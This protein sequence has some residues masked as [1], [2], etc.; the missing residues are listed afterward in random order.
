MSS[1][2]LGAGGGQSANIESRDT[3]KRCR[4]G[5]NDT[6]T[7][8]DSRDNESQATRSTGA[9]VGKQ[10]I[11]AVRSP[12]RKK[13]RGQGG[14]GTQRLDGVAS[15]KAKER[16]PGRQAS[17][18]DRETS[19][20]GSPGKDRAKKAAKT[21]TAQPR[22]VPLHK[23][24]RG[25]VVK[26]NVPCKNAEGKIMYTQRRRGRVVSRSRQSNTWLN[27]NLEAAGD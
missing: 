5:R 8:S 16:S 7:E 1:R 6:A 3:R 13:G 9:R 24:L 21:A 10:Y 19:E 12:E 26:Y 4:D 18:R 22:S 11:D 2:A 17:K 15:K 20:Q 27:V 23:R 25:K 14:Q